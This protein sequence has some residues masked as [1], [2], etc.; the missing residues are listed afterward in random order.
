MND[1][2]LYDRWRDERS[3]VEVDGGFADRLMDEVRRSQRQR[4]SA[5]LSRGGNGRP[6]SHGFLTAAL[7]VVGVVVGFL[8]VGS[9]IAFILFASSEGF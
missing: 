1:S 4:P 6:I 9:V 7:V 3:A 5:V 8:R 2:R